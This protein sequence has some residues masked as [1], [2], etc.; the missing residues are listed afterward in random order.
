MLLDIG[1]T[2]LVSPNWMFV[3]TL[4]S[5]YTTNKGLPLYPDGYAYAGILNIQVV[6]KQ[7]P[8]TAGLVASELSPL[9]ML[10]ISSEMK[11]ETAEGY[12]QD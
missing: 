6:E 10:Q 9:E 11:K 5:P 8:A 4:T 12:T 7:W 3:A 2:V 1:I